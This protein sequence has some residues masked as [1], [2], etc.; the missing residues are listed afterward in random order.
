MK[1]QAYFE[2]STNFDGLRVLHD[3]HS[4]VWRLHA[5]LHDRTHALVLA[6]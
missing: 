6:T 3:C 5:V 2:R 1:S 4:E